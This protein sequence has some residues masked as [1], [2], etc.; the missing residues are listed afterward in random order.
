MLELL[1]PPS[2]FKNTRNWRQYFSL[3][4]YLSL[5]FF[6]AFL[7]VAIAI[8]LKVWMFDALGIHAPYLLLFSAVVYSAWFGGFGPGIFSIALSAVAA[9]FY[10]Y[11]PGADLFEK[12]TQSTIFILEG[13]LVTVLATIHKRSETKLE[14]QEEHFK[15]LSEGIRDHAVYMLDR[16]GDIVSWNIGAEK[17]KG[18]RSEEVL[19]HNFEIFY[20]PEDRAA[21]KPKQQ[22][23]Q[24]IALGR[25]EEEGWRL[26]K[27]GPFWANTTLTVL[28][29]PEGNIQGFVKVIRDVSERKMAEE[30]IRHQAF[31]DPLTGLANR[32]LLEERLEQVIHHARMKK[33]KVGILFLD[34][35]FFKNINDALGHKVGDAILKEVTQRLQNSIR[36]ADIVARFGGDEFVVLLSNLEN[37]DGCVRVAEGVINELRKVFKV[38]KYSLYLSVSIGISMYP[39]DADNVESL[40][41]NADIAMYKV[42]ESG[43]NGYDF[44]S[45]K[46]SAKLSQKI[47]LENSLPAG[48][49]NN[50]FVLYYQPIIDVRNNSVVAAEALLRW[51]HP[52]LGFL[53][54]NEFI[55][56]VENTEAFFEL[57]N[58]IIRSACE[59]NLSWQKLGFKIKVAVN[60][61]VRQLSHANFVL[62]VKKIIAETGMQPELLELEITESA[63]ITNIETNVKIIKEL[64]AMGLHITIDDFGVGHS[65]LSYLKDFPIDTIKIDQTFVHESLNNEQDRSI[66]KA[67]LALSE[68][69]KLDVIAEG[70]EN[71]E[72]LHSLEQLN[73]HLI[74]GFFFSKAIPAEAFVEHYRNNYL[75]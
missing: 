59:Q 30:T 23:R 46:M 45:H 72:Q 62:A 47:S 18:F 49:E 1:N 28:K 27:S 24:A 35:D 6:V 64:K 50:E 11:H 39:D 5:R 66:I 38:D 58:W 43:R 61:S 29:D 3:E 44:Y 31:H 73:C 21:G 51:N 12:E 56:F 17:I 40:L 60:I 14:K 68:G 9:Y 42:K 26:R 69:L 15:F 22:L 53:M 19:G 54:P 36:D 67:I 13:L 8:S 4:R 32:A 10:F 70:V 57:G 65:S 63:T 37:S 33:E 20:T 34:L 52:H 71:S 75:I 2:N 48:L 55:P 16:D 7:V 25:F 41:K 74:Q